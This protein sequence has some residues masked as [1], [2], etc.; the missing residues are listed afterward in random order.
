MILGILVK[1]I[2]YHKKT[3]NVV[4]MLYIDFVY[5]CIKSKGYGNC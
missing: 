1:T 2:K 4:H 5:L 3:Q